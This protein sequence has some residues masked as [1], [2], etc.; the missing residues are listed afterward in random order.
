MK[1]P[2]ITKARKTKG[3]KLNEIKFQNSN[4]YLLY[5][6]VANICFWDRYFVIFI[7][8]IIYSTFINPSM[9]LLIRL[10]NS[11]NNNTQKMLTIIHSFKIMDNKLK[12]L[13]TFLKVSSKCYI[14]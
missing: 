4:D 14:I 12:Y 3:S 7:D 11:F 1:K 5:L 6:I 10:S 2:L 9:I 13:N 8:S